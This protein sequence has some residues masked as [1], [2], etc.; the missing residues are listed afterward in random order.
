MD[1]E[2]TRGRGGGWVHVPCPGSVPRPGRGGRAHPPR[3]PRLVR[4]RVGPRG[5]R[6]RRRRTADPRRRPPRAELRPGGAPRQ[7]AGP[8][9]QGDRLRHAEGDQRGRPGAP[10]DGRPACLAPARGRP[11]ARR[12]RGVACPRRRLLAAPREDAR[13]ER[14]GPGLRGDARLLRRGGLPPARGAPGG[15]GGGES[16]SAH[17]PAPLLQRPAGRP[18]R[19]RRRPQRPARPAAPARCRRASRAPCRAGRGPPDARPPS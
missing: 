12:A 8:A 15:L 18:A 6:A 14:P 4:D 5:V 9:G 1:G 2:A 7:P 3:P 16:L 13:T 10:R 17:G 11:R 19:V